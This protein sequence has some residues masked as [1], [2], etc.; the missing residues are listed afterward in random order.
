M[1]VKVSYTSN[2]EDIPEEVANIVNGVSTDLNK[3]QT[4]VDEL[5]VDLKDRDL[6][7]AKLKL[8]AGMEKLQ[9]MYARLGDC[10]VILEGYEKVINHQIPQQE[11]VVEEKVPPKQEKS[12]KK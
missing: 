2:I 4:F 11:P 5:G 10:Q 8:K 3:F 12:S 6:S 1:Q 9:K 7:L